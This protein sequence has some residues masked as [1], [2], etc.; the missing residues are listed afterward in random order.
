MTSRHLF[1][2]PPLDI[3]LGQ[4]H[5]PQQALALALNQHAREERTRIFN[6]IHS[7]DQAND[8]R[9]NHDVPSE[10]MLSVEEQKL[11]DAWIVKIEN[12]FI[13]PT[14]E[15]DFLIL[16][17]VDQSHHKGASGGRKILTNYKHPFTAIYTL[18]TRERLLN[19]LSGLEIGFEEA[20]RITEGEIK[21][22]RQDA[23]RPVDYQFFKL[24][25]SDMIWFGLQRSAGDG[26]RLRF[27]E[28]AKVFSNHWLKHPNASR[29]YSPIEWTSSPVRPLSAKTVPQF[30][31]KR[32]ASQNRPSRNTLHDIGGHRP[33]R[34]VLEEKPSAPS[35]VKPALDERPNEAHESLIDSLLDH[36][37]WHAE[38]DFASSVMDTSRW[39]TVP[40]RTGASSPI[41]IG[42]HHSPNHIQTTDQMNNLLRVVPDGKS[43]ME[44]QSND[45][46]SSSGTSLSSSNSVLPLQTKD[47]PL[48]SLVHSLAHHEDLHTLPWVTSQAGTPDQPEFNQYEL[49]DPYS[50]PDW[51]EN[52]KIPMRR[53]ATLTSLLKL[54]PQ[55]VL[56]ALSAG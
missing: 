29:Q 55:L 35:L 7:L 30:S 47:A 22:C 21:Q 34:K 24:S 1:L 42:P 37:G 41:R 28:I 20:S 13:T 11:I 12:E 50:L 52:S 48:E 26:E 9:R 46:R 31:Q 25:L 27:E 36:F 14:F 8:P 45:Q 53:L 43:G 2:Y 33:G 54:L 6:N 49:L 17:P 40:S 4:D 51:S 16:H 3:K 10:D 15:R 39:D 38:L 18:N 23:H 56:G 44:N 5:D 32:E 19:V